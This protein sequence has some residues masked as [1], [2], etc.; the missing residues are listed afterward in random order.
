MRI[1]LN[2]TQGGG[3]GDENG[4]LE[5]ARN[6]TVI[7]INDTI[8]FRRYDDIYIDFNLNSVITAGDYPARINNTWMWKDDEIVWRESNWSDA[9][10]TRIVG[11]I[12]STPQLGTAN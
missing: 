9:I 11:D 2:T 7:M 10:E 4:Y 6:D 5:I 1:I 12:I 8:M 3:V